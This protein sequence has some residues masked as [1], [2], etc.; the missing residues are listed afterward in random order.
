MHDNTY[1]LNCQ[2]SS[3]S[4]IGTSTGKK[5]SQSG[6][7]TNPATELPD[8]GNYIKKKLLDIRDQKWQ[9]SFKFTHRIA[10]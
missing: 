9:F 2:K 1:K 4:V 8:F 6:L 7:F 3:S 10:N 5:I